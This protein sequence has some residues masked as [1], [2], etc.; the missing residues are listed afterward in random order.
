M[1]TPNKIVA[2]ISLLALATVA[3]ADGLSTSMSPQIGGGIGQFDGG[4]SSNTATAAIGCNGTLN[5][6][7]GCAT[8]LPG[9]I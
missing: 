7:T 5:L 2:I 1:S 8:P 4:V 9:G 6:S 3:R